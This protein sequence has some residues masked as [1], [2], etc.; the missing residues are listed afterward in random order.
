MSDTERS[1]GY[2]LRGA[3]ERRNSIFARRAFSFFGYADYF[4]HY[5]PISRILTRLSLIA[6]FPHCLPD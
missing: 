3:M 5:V 4:Q 2:W 1:S 6:Q